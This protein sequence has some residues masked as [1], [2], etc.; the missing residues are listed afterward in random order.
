M[1]WR[2][3]LI[4]VPRISTFRNCTLATGRL[5]NFVWFLADSIGCAAKGVGLRPLSCWDCGFESYR[6]YRCLSVVG[7]VFC[8]VEISATGRS[9]V[10]RSCVECDVSECDLGTSTIRMSRPTTS[11]DLLKS[12]ILIINNL[13]SF[14]D[15]R[16]FFVVTEKHSFVWDRILIF[17]YYINFVLI[18]VTVLSFLRHFTKPNDTAW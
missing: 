9:Q 7:I 17:I 14:N 4:F 18:Y 8:Q 5:Q 2:V 6:G 12:M 15:I 3:M 11:V 1:S 16:K 10:Q 13:V